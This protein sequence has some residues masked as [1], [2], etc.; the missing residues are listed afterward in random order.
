MREENKKR[1][2]YWNDLCAVDIV[3][4]H[5]YQRG[6]HVARCSF[7]IMF[8]L[9]HLY[10]LYSNTRRRCCFL[11]HSQDDSTQLVWQI[12]WPV[13]LVARRGIFGLSFDLCKKRKCSCKFTISFYRVFPF[14][15]ENFLE[16]LTPFRS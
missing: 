16:G 1:E 2:S 8:A 13:F 12:K 7:G 14:S 15:T 6:C 11:S 9:V 10:T 3:H 5:T 4:M